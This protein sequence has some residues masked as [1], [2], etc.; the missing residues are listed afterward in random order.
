MPR[1]HDFRG[2]EAFLK[3]KA[4]HGL[5]E[6]H[7]R[8]LK[9]RLAYLVA[10]RGKVIVSKVDSAFALAWVKARGGNPECVT[11]CVRSFS[12]FAPYCPIKG[13]K[14]SLA[15]GFNER[16]SPRKKSTRRPHKHEESRPL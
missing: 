13:G 1:N 6:R 14:I 3:E 10:D 9:N 15:T 16:K 12:L 5:S 2:R 8:D 7:T 11:A 4:G